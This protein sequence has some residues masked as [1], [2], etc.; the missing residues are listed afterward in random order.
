MMAHKKC[1]PTGF[2]VWQ[3][4]RSEGYL[5][6]RDDF[7]E[8][9]GTLF[10]PAT[11]QMMEPLGLIGYFPAIL[12]DTG[13][14]LPDEIALVLYGSQEDYKTASR[15]STSG[16]AYGAL[17]GAVFNFSR[18]GE[19]PKSKSAFPQKY[20]GELE[21][22]TPYYLR[23]DEIDWRDGKTKVYCAR[24]HP[25]ISLAEFTKHIKSVIDA[26]SK[27]N[28][29]DIDGSILVCEADY[30]L[31]WEHS[32]SSKSLF[33][34]FAPVLNYPMLADKPLLRSVPEL[35][36]VPYEGIDVQA[37]DNLDVRL[38][39]SVSRQNQLTPV[40]LKLINEV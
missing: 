29:L 31:Y 7:V 9:L 40:H 21:L 19:I 14:K 11:V 13:F 15:E 20:E 4:Y 33:P 16:R 38:L 37:G 39:A 35:N 23:D 22:G 30:I 34:Y 5:N 6:R 32:K 28:A 3:G 17:H 1:K 36:T 27:Q 2:R 26:W 24:R 8:K 18:G 10:I 12:P 25:D